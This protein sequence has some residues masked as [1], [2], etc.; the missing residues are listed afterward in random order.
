MLFM[1]FTDLSPKVGMKC[2][3]TLRPNSLRLLRSCH[4][5]FGL[6]E[7]DELKMHIDK[8]LLTDK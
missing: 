3:A 8:I 7:S 1:V 2:I 4:E 6:R 5:E